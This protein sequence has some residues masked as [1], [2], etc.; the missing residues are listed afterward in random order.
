ME[1]VVIAAGLVVLVVV[2]A[3]V[4]RRRRE[5]DPPTQPRTEPPAQLDRADF[6]D[7]VDHEW[8]LVVFSSATCH[9]CADMVAK[10]GA[11]ASRAVAVRDVEFGAE[12]ALHAK[13]RIDAVPTTVL[14]DATGIVRAAFVGRATAT[15]LW[16]AVARARDPHLDLGPGCA[17]H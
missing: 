5:V 11:V 15:D 3:T 13:Y 17:N 16:A 9:T 7:V 4:L 14:A 12:R 10:A 8:L 1:R 2:V 6:P